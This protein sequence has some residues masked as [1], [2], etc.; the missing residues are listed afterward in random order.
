MAPGPHSVGAQF[1]PTDPTLFQGSAATAASLTVAKEDA[2]IVYSSDNATA[3]KV[4]TSGG[5]L[6]AN[7]LVLQLGVKDAEPDAA[8]SAGAT[9]I[10]SKIG[11][12]GTLGGQ[13][14]TVYV[15][16]RGGPG[17]GFDRVWMGGPGV[18]KLPGISTTARASAVTLTGG[19]VA[20]PHRSR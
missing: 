12:V 1:T 6:A 16:D 9:R 18:L 20:V 11:G 17:A 15:E 13:A 7:A 10:G 4:T 19:N 8:T 2:S 5:T 3:M 14:F